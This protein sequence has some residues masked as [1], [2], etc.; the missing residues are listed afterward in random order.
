MLLLSPTSALGEA[1]AGLTEQGEGGGRRE[2]G[3]LAGRGLKGLEFGLK[4]W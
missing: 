1:G 2:G 4:F 3:H